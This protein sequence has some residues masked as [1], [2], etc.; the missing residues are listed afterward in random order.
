MGDPASHHPTI[1]RMA[2]MPTALILGEQL[3][4]LRNVACYASGFIKRQTSLRLQH[5]RTHKPSSVRLSL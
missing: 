2:G 5:L 3:W 4:Q 1:D